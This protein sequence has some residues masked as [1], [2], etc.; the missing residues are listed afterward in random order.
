MHAICDINI[1]KNYGDG[2]RSAGMAVYWRPDVCISGGHSDIYPSIHQYC[3]PLRFH[4]QV[5]VAVETLCSYDCASF[6]V[7]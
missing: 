4:E 2:R 5:P 6:A 1:S 3:K 7:N